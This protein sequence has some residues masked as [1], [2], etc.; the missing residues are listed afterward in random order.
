MACSQTPSILVF[1]HMLMTWHWYQKK[2][3][4]SPGICWMVYTLLFSLSVDVLRKAYEIVGNINPFEPMTTGL[5]YLSPRGHA[6]VAFQVQMWPCL[7]WTQLSTLISRQESTWGNGVRKLKNRSD[8][9]VASDRAYYKECASCQMKNSCMHP[10]VAIHVPLL[11]NIVAQVLSY[12]T[13]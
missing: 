6:G 12:S 7:A 11:N 5:M 8:S 9:D 4:L 3:W 2:T 13:V 1:G 10:T